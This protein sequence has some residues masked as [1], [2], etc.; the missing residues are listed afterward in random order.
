MANKSDLIKAL[1]NNDAGRA[2]K[3][4]SVFV[5][6]LRGSNVA[7]ELGLSTEDYKKFSYAISTGDLKEA[8][9]IWGVGLDIEK[10]VKFYNPFSGRP[11]NKT[12]D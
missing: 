8:R 11:W 9:K 2:K 3:A 7:K 4:L 10:D 6:S 1:K 12:N 5:N